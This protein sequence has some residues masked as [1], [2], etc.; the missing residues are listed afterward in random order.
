M[1]IM[2]QIIREREWKVIEKRNRGERIKKDKERDKSKGRE[3]SIKSERDEEI[4]LQ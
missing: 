3:R 1:N 4:Q 2:I